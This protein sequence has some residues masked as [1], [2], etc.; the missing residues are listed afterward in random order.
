ME[1]TYFI[2]Y[3]DVNSKGRTL[4]RIRKE[5]TFVRTKES[6]LFRFEST[7]PASRARITATVS[8]SASLNISPR[9]FA[10]SRN[11]LKEAKTNFYR[12]QGNAS[13]INYACICSGI[14]RKYTTSKLSSRE[15]EKSWRIC[16]SSQ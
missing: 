12:Q 3:T 9:D 5:E 1:T 2:P 4:A 15:E 13:S 14:S 7:S 11:P 10:S 8:N 16:V 6:Y